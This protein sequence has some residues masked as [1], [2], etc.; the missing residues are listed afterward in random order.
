MHLHH[1]SHL[2]HGL[3]REVVDYILAAFQERSSF[4]IETITLPE[5]LGD[6]PCALL[7]PATGT[8]VERARVRLERRGERTWES[9]VVDAPPAR[10]RL[11]TIVAGPH[12]GSPCVLYTAY[13]GPQAPREPGDPAIRDD[14][15]RDASRA[16]WAN[17][18]LAIGG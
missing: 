15:E 5:H 6:V 13:G 16:F 4:F 9:R 12:D 2:D 3:S 1:D 17:H 11:V 8:S 7:G 18:A 10:S 14:A